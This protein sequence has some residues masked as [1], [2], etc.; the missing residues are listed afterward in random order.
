MLLSAY[1][2]QSSS[3]MMSG[4]DSLPSSQPLHRMR[5]GRSD[6][7]DAVVGMTPLLPS[8]S[9]HAAQTFSFGAASFEDEQVS[10]MMYHTCAYS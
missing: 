7:F 2:S 5:S 1:N 3:F 9:T 8:I 6:S 10:H 4:F